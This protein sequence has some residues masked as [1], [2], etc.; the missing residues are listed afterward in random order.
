MLRGKY[1][2]KFKLN[3]SLGK[4]ISSNISCSENELL[5]IRVKHNYAN[6]KHFKI[7]KPKIFD[8]SWAFLNLQPYRLFCNIFCCKDMKLVVIWQSYRWNHEYFD[9]NCI[10]LDLFRF[11]N[12]LS[13]VMASPR[14]GFEVCHIKS[15]GFPFLV[16]STRPWLCRSS[17]SLILLVWP[18]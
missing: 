9:M 16:D 7:K 1:S 14:L 6:P 5:T 8:T 3:S 15:H 11:F 18:I 12:F 2:L 13:R 4:I 17:R 10:N